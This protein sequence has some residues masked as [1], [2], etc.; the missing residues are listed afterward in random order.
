MASLPWFPSLVRCAHG[1][2]TASDTREPRTETTSEG[3]GNAEVS[4]SRPTGV[5]ED[6]LDRALAEA[7]AGSEAE[8][9]VVVRQAV[10][11]ADSGKAE[12][13]R[14]MELTVAE[15][16]A[17]LAD[18]PNGSVASRWNWWLGAL[19]VAYGGYEEFQVRRYSREG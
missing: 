19:E 14:G 5:N 6:E 3:V 18:A 1:V 15:I 11:L 2:L 9:R 7:F 16:V 17:N 8:R 12:R 13:D 10:D 4:T